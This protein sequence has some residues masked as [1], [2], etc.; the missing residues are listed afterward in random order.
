MTWFSGYHD[1][2]SPGTED[3]VGLPLGQICEY[4]MQRRSGIDVLLTF[5]QILGECFLQERRQIA[6]EAFEGWYTFF[7]SVRSWLASPLMRRLAIAWY[8]SKSPTAAAH[9][10]RAESVESSAEKVQE[11]FTAASSRRLLRHL[12]NIV[13]AIVK[14]W[15]PTR[16]CRL[17]YCPWIQITLSVNPPRCLSRNPPSTF[18][19]LHILLAT[20]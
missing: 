20:Y 2:P 3:S 16:L 12:W 5:H 11:S 10:R 13:S 4:S 15:Y 8:E 1:Q 14:N 6:F 19:S 17:G 9:F 7:G 18:C